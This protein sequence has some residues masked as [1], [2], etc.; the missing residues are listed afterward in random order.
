[1]IFVLHCG[2]QVMISHGNLAHNLA[3]ITHELQLDESSKIVSWLPQYHDMGLIGSYMGPL[4]SG[5]TG[6]YQ[7]PMAFLKNPVLWMQLITKY[8]GTHMQAPNF[9]FA[10]VTRK[11]KVQPPLL[12]D[13]KHAHI[14]LGVRH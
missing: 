5:G 3:S 13:L 11:F 10:L 9:A 7:S 2:T 6:F 14:V 1:M 8:R 12:Y 4:Y